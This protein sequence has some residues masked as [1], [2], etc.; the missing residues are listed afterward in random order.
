MARNRSNTASDDFVNTSRLK[1]CYYWG[2]TQSVEMDTKRES[3]W[4]TSSR[5]VIIINTDF[6]YCWRSP[7]PHWGNVRGTTIIRATTIICHI[8]MIGHM[9]ASQPAPTFSTIWGCWRPKQLNPVMGAKWQCFRLET[10]VPSRRWRWITWVC[11]PVRFMWPHRPLPASSSR[12]MWPCS[13]T[14]QGPRF[15]Y[16]SENP[17]EIPPASCQNSF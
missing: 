13:H 15:S 17:P 5:S 2:Q 16:L 6:L 9:I 1:A 10:E 12:S 14:T 3:Y 4:Q 11:T 7:L 8:W